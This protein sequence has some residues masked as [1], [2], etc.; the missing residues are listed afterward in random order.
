MNHFR[1]AMPF[2]AE[3]RDDGTVRFRLWAPAAERVTLRLEDQTRRIA[4][5]PLAEGW[6]E[7]VTPRAGP[8]DRYRFELPDG[9][10]VPD[11]ASRRQSGD[12]HGPSVVVDPDAYRWR[13][14]RWRGRPWHE[15][16][17]YELHVGTFSA[18]GAYDGVRRRLE[19][20]ARLGVT[21]I[22]LM[23][24]AD[25]AGR[26]NWGYDG[27][28]PFAPHARYGAP[29]RLKALIDAAHEQE[30]MVFLDVVYNHF[31]PEGNYL[32]R[33]APQTFTDKEPT[34][35]G[36]AI[37]F[38]RRPVRDLFIHNASYW[39]EEY[40]FDGLRLD[41][42][43][44]IV[45]RAQPPLLLEIATAVRAVAGDREVHLV[46]END[47]NAAWL[48]KRAADGTVERYDAQWNDDFHHGAH[49]L[50][51]GESH[52]YY[53][54]YIEQPIRYLGRT[55]AEGFA[56]QGEY[57][58][59][60]QRRRGEPSA[61]LPPKAFVGFLQNHDQVGNRAFGERL[62]RLAPAAALT[63][64]TAV[65]LLAPSIPLL[66]MGEEHGADEPFCFFADFQGELAEAVRRGR[67]REM[68][69]YPGFAGATADIPDPIAEATYRAS[70][71]DWSKQ[72]EPAHRDWLEHYRR[73][74][75]VRRRHIMPR[76]A[77]SPSGPAS[78]ET[79]PGGYLRVLW[80]L[81]D[82]AEL[83]LIARLGD[84]PEGPSEIRIAGYPLWTSA[85]IALTGA[86]L[87]PLPAWFVGWFI[88]DTG[89]RGRSR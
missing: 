31:G 69:R 23:P 67:R 57:S 61:E 28:L 9:F 36:E 27:V 89:A 7:L 58:A 32:H 82:G 46:V 86:P 26:W 72:A 43:H 53:V 59:Y 84:G 63:A 38:S 75:T 17:I 87:G 56:Y 34:P 6:H 50:L 2:G 85:P 64:L 40:R 21:A 41:A 70:I 68:A 49:V 22:E 78:H 54:D 80:R 55:L 42:V 39:I 60:R 74:L 30:L 81:G 5:A 52:A 48:L 25:F 35:W 20:L 71:I 66:F 11:P 79:G 8:G 77:A 14:P 19:Q 24:I 44:A 73:L 37:D 45:D 4:M 10:A 51:T 13:H 47:D 62:V 88:D 65:Q 33:Y 12:V 1:H 15:A 83:T 18:D 3:C 29:D 16:V 76:L